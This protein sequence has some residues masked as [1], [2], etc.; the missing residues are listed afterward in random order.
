MN[1]EK[2]IKNIIYIIS[3][4][5]DL[6]LLYLVIFVQTNFLYFFLVACLTIFGVLTMEMYLRV[7]HNIDEK[8]LK[9]VAEIE[10][11][12]KSLTVKLD[13]SSDA[14]NKYTDQVGNSLSKDFKSS[15]N[16]LS[17]KL[18]TSISNV[19]ESINGSIDKKFKLVNER[20]GATTLQID[21]ASKDQAEKTKNIINAINLGA[22]KVEEN[23]K[24]L[25]QVNKNLLDKINT[26]LTANNL[27]YWSY[28]KEKRVE[29]LLEAV[30]NIFKAKSV[31]YV[32][33]RPDRNDF[34]DEFQKNKSKITILEIYKP[35]T[36]YF[37]NIPWVDEVIEGD[38]SDATLKLKKNFDVVF[39]WH[40]P[41]H[42]EEK[43][44]AETLKRLESVAK[45]YVILGC[46]WGKVEQNKNLEEKNKFEKHV[47]Y[48]DTGYFEKYGYETDYFGIQNNRG[49]NIL[50]IK[51]I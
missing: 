25:D 8:F 14:N 35:N 47:S 28:V 2:R 26:Q 10:L 4:I 5:I 6:V 49:S 22:S 32:G 48:L 27:F 46:P 17:K 7:Q 18:E 23:S 1:K 24:H 42:V 13:H 50:S 12:E 31:L 45:K 38:V 11:L 20:L 9:N 15:N 40:G 44:I 39:W 34:L 41:E 37:K 30:P 33:A 19:N 51:K 43:K 16:S 3:G 21:H 36:D 29:R